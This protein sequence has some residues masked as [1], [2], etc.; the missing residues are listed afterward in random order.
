MPRHM[1]EAEIA[2]MDAMQ[3]EG[4]EAVAIIKKL[5]VARSRKG[6]EGPSQSSVYRYLD[7]DAYQRGVEETR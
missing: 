5:R 7:G 2:T 6:E 3:K 1:N 4:K